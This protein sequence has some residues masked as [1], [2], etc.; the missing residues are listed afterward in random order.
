MTQTTSSVFVPLRGGPR[1]FSGRLVLS[2]QSTP[3][4][5]PLRDSAGSADARNGTDFGSHPPRRR[6]RPGV[7]THGARGTAGPVRPCQEGLAYRAPPPFL[8][9][10]RAVPVAGPPRLTAPLLAVAQQSR[11][12]HQCTLKESGATGSEHRRRFAAPLLNVNAFLTL[13][14]C[15]KTGFARVQE[16]RNLHA[17]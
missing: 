6:S 3:R 4:P 15:P 12:I 5:A 11:A 17:P 14:R 10:A 9:C 1:I 8:S 13:S 2:A 16:Q 7:G